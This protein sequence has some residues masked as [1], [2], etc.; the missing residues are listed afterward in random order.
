MSRSFWINLLFAVLLSGVLFWIS[1]WF[2]DVYTH[3]G[4][5]IAVPDL[6]GKTLNEVEDLLGDENLSYKVLDSVFNRN[7]APGSV[8]EQFPRKG[9]EVKRN[10]VIAL[11]IAA[12]APQKVKIDAVKDLSLRQAIGQLSKKGI[13]VKK[14]E[15][16]TSSYTNLVLG[17]SLN[18]K[19]IHAG[20]KIYK[21]E[22]VILHVGKSENITFTVPNLIGLSEN[23][24]KRKILEAGLNIGKVTF[25]NNSEEAKK[26][27]RVVQQSLGVGG[28]VEPGKNINIILAAPKSPTE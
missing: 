14:L 23:Y 27:S 25:K 5:K 24:A 21:G 15:Y 11:T 2:T 16:T 6:K 8:I 22:E 4:E 1:L 19:K 18:G 12:I 17:M 7:A 26:I 28:S 3:H 13:F 9:Q 20:E 10:R